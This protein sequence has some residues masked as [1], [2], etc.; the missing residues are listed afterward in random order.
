MCPAFSFISGGNWEKFTACNNTCYHLKWPGILKNATG[1]GVLYWFEKLLP[2]ELK[3]SLD[4]DSTLIIRL[5]VSYLSL[6]SFDHIIPQNHSIAVP[7]PN[8]NITSL[9]RVVEAWK[10]ATPTNDK[11]LHKNSPG[12]EVENFR[13]AKML[14]SAGERIVRT[15]VS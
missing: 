6:A 12:M 8:A 13:S 14:V 15:N 1:M 10:D 11:V 9:I 2:I 3:L 7:Q 4:S 5:N